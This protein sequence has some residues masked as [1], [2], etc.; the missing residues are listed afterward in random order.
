MGQDKRKVYASGDALLESLSCGIAQFRLY[1]DGMIY[2]DRINPEGVRIF[3]KESGEN[4]RTEVHLRELLSQEDLQR[5]DEVLKMLMRDNGRITFEYP[6]SADDDRPIWI[7]GVLQNLGNGED[8]RGEVAYKQASFM[9]ITPTRRAL[10]RAVQSEKRVQMEREQ[11][12]EFFY[13]IFN[14]L[15]ESSAVVEDMEEVLS[16]VGKYLDADRVSIYEEREEGHFCDNTYEWCAE[17]IDSVKDIRQNLPYSREYAQEIV[18]AKGYSFCPDVRKLPKNDREFLEKDKCCSIFLCGIFD[19][20]KNAI[21]YISVE[22]CTR[23]RDEWE[24][25]SPE[26]EAVLH[27]G[28]LL[29]NYVNKVRN[30]EHNE[31]FRQRLIDTERRV[32]A[33]TDAIAALG[34]AYLVVFQCDLAKNTVELVAGERQ[35]EMPEEPPK[36]PQGLFN[37][38]IERQVSMLYQEEMHT[39]LDKNT[40]LERM[41]NNTMLSHDYQSM[42]GR[43]IRASLIYGGDQIVLFAVNNIEDERNAEREY[44]RQL[45]EVRR[46]EN[47][48][49]K[50]IMDSIPGGFKIMRDDGHFSIEYMSPRLI[51]MLGY[52]VEEQQTVLQMHITAFIHP[53]DRQSVYEEIIDQIRNNKNMYLKYRMLRKDGSSFWIEDI[54][55]QVKFDDGEIKYYSVILDVDEAE[56]QTIALK[57]ANQTVLRERRQYRDA[58]TRNALYYFHF[59]VTEGIIAED[60]V[61]INGVNFME[62]VGVSAP[63]GFD[64]YCQRVLFG[65]NPLIEVENPEVLTTEYLKK[66]FE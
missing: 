34:K 39:F 51:E 35:G 25:E 9:N 64:E 59:D 38:F 50:T 54:G 58:L 57:N 30:M 5:L 37:L 55:H 14:R 28:Q 53:D 26:R 16:F 18:G 44:Q 52:S 62:A 65:D 63:I 20:Q 22:S 41:K 31:V 33:Q 10:E 11:N 27:A 49:L 60:V 1:K 43:W 3:A 42:S 8:E 48:Q 66:S 17:G 46:R 45:K 24:E 23:I 21:G 40:M 7:T 56:R 36:E 13:E 61:D 12:A 19:I 29:S 15:Y 32:G 2:V 4:V 47:I 6:I